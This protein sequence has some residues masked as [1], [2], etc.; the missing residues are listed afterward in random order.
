MGRD[1]NREEFGLG[2][3][4]EEI[5]FRQEAFLS[6]GEPAEQTAAGKIPVGE[7]DVFALES[8]ERI[9]SGIC[10]PSPT[11][12]PNRIWSSV[13]VLPV[14][15]RYIPR[16]PFRSWGSGFKQA[17]NGTLGVGVSDEASKEMIFL[18]GDGTLPAGGLEFVFHF[19]QMLL[20]NGQIARRVGT[21]RV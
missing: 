4:R 14:G 8:L 9:C 7:L 11:P 2:A 16:N 1:Q 19:G 13:E 21:R 18:L 6:G 3:D 17:L 20:G 15:V 5:E 10:S 12:D